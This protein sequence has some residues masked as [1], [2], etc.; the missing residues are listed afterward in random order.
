MET[1]K[2][3]IEIPKQNAFEVFSTEKGVDP[4]LVKIREEIDAFIPDASTKKGRD[5]IASMAYKVARSKTALDEVGKALVADLK[6]L[7]KKI[8]AERKRVRETLDAWRDEVRKPLTDW[9][10]AEEDRKKRHQ[11]RLDM[12]L[13]AHTDGMTAQ[14]IAE[15]LGA[16]SEVAIDYSFEEFQMLAH[17][18]KTAAVAKLSSALEERKKQDEEQEELARLRAESQARAQKEREEFMVRE[19]EDRARKEAERAAQAEQLAAAMRE[20]EAVAAAERAKREAVEAE[21]RAERAEREA[22]ARAKA[23]AEA[24]RQRIERAAHEAKKLDEERA[25]DTEH[26]KTANREALDA[27]VAG[28]LSETDAKTAISLIVKN[29]IPRI[30]MVY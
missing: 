8:D 28:G 4:F 19:A 18:A 6:E 22:A 2:N 23:A 12:L 30:K 16:I 21:Q 24:E 11:M 25:R 20:A 26:R 1:E 9:E 14:Q 17:K 29:Q 27:F 3:I 13:D 7:P 15:K 10:C 5:E